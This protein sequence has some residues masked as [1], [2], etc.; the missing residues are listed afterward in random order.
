MKRFAFATLAV[1]LLLGVAFGQ[2]PAA[3]ARPAGDPSTAAAVQLLQNVKAGNEE[4]LRKQ[5]A[6]LQQLE[7]LEKSADQLRI[8]SKRG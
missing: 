8:F 5:Q 3:P 2:P 6:T 7:E 1:V 4:T